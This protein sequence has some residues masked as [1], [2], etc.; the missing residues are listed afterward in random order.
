MSQVAAS[1]STPF[2]LAH[3]LFISRFVRPSVPRFDGDAR[4]LSGWAAALRETPDSAIER[5]KQANLLV[6]FAPST[7]E[8][9]REA[10]GSIYGVTQLRAMLKTRGL[11]VGGRKDELTAKLVNVDCEGLSGDI[12]ALQLYHCSEAGKQMVSQFEERKEQAHVRAA[13]AINAKDYV[14]AIH[15][16]QTIED[17]LGFPKA[18]FE[19]ATRPEL[20]ELVMTVKPKIL[21]GCSEEVMAGLRIAMVLQCLSGRHAP[22]KLLR[23][24][25]SGICLD[26]ETAARMIYFLARHIED[27]QKWKQ[28]GVKHVTHLAATDSCSVCTS[29]NGRKWRIEQAPELPQAECT[30]A[31]GCR[32]LYLPVHDF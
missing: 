10:L 6:P 15:E 23:D 16:Y 30:H 12:V 25:D 14:R 31:Y 4:Q 29:L 7:P 5:F 19:G 28:I 8:A 2:R 18:E 21:E 22:K 24:F 3:S 11:K 26:A 32:C 9:L 17:D 20:L 1:P 13:A 27:M